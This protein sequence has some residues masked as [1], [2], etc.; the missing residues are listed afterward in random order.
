MSLHQ[1][2]LDQL[3]ISWRKLSRDERES[4]ASTAGEE[5]CVELWGRCWVTED[6][7]PRAPVPVPQRDAADPPERDAHVFPST[8]LKILCGSQHLLSH[9][10]GDPGLRVS[11]NSGPGCTTE[12]IPLLNSGIFRIEGSGEN[13]SGP[14]PRHLRSCPVLTTDASGPPGCWDQSLP[15]PAEPGLSCWER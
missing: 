1:P 2:H 5:S 7:E 8:S 9:K 14:A 12:A 10:T 3:F 4:S 6:G 15:R 11:Q 13:L